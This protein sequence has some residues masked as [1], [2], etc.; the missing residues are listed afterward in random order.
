MADLVPVIYSLRSAVNE[1]KSP[2]EQTEVVVDGLLKLER[3]YAGFDELQVVAAAKQM[4]DEQVVHNGSELSV[5][6]HV[7]EKGF[8]PVKRALAHAHIPETLSPDQLLDFKFKPAATN[9]KQKSGGF[10]YAFDFDSLPMFE[11]LEVHLE[12]LR[13][14]STDRTALTKIMIMDLS[15]LIEHPQWEEA[16][17]LLHKALS[18]PQD[19]DLKLLVLTLFQRFIVGFMGTS[20]GLDTT[21][22]ALRYLLTEWALSGGENGTPL[23]DR[24]VLRAQLALF[25]SAL[26]CS[27]TSLQ[28]PYQREVDRAL[29]LFFVLLSRGQLRPAEGPVSLLS[30]LARADGGEEALIALLRALHPVSAFN[31]AVETGLL[32]TL[33]HPSDASAQALHST[34][35][36]LR[37]VLSLVA[38]FSFGHNPATRFVESCAT[39][40][41]VGS[42]HFDF[43]AHEWR[44][45]LQQL[46]APAVLGRGGAGDYLAPVE[47]TNKRFLHLSRP[48]SVF[49]ALLNPTEGGDARLLSWVVQQLETLLAAVSRTSEVTTDTPDGRERI[50]PLMGDALR[51]CLV[52]CASYLDVGI[53]AANTTTAAFTQ[54]ITQRVLELEAVLAHVRGGE[55]AA[56]DGRRGILR[57][58]LEVADA[59]RQSSILLKQDAPFSWGA[60]LA[61]VNSWNVFASESSAETPVA[62]VQLQDSALTLVAALVDGGAV[63]AGGEVVLL[64]SA[65]QFAVRVVNSGA[66]SPLLPR[67][68]CL[69]H[70][71]LHREGLRRRT[72]E[73][74]AVILALLRALLQP[75]FVDA[76]SE[77]ARRRAVAALTQALFT[78]GKEDL[79]R[80]FGDKEVDAMLT[81]ALRAEMSH[82][83]CFERA[84]CE[85]LP[86]PI[87]GTGDV[88][89]S[90]FQLLLK[91]MRLGYADVVGE[92][93][94]QGWSAAVTEGTG[95]SLSDLPLLHV[96][97]ARGGECAA[98]L[99]TTGIFPYLLRLLV[100]G[101][102]HPGYVE[103]LR[104]RLGTSAVVPA[105]SDDGVDI[106]TVFCLLTSA[107]LAGDTVDPRALL[108]AP[109]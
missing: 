53:S 94:Q 57:G 59:Q 30:A 29:V 8:E 78:A 39:V 40:S 1:S 80:I 79:V 91:L 48:V 33:L 43:S 16:L 28:V 25:V 26:Q 73:E 46:A 108:C 55:T 6:N 51:L 107:A 18:A 89:P 77:D 49:P 86:S 71:A 87:P 11:G 21:I 52:L 45:E 13:A 5:K 17:Q 35:L 65:A 68:I 41:D 101:L 74:D 69:L 50:V 85:E 47:G 67:C 104:S 15:E 106:T 81:G 27:A 12:C 92:V 83:D 3:L 54:T 20:Q 58:L 75:Q 32:G 2:S 10:S 102:S 109:V 38:A 98:Q 24:R 56:L 99:E 63:V 7:H 96:S 88:F 70:S 22:S 66:T 19:P 97:L 60:V 82:P 31:Y 14:N 105:Q 62:V 37:V 103:Q 34:G 9:K 90:A 23:P 64:E 84:Y 4:L 93:V 36:R 61:A 100:A 76:L 72:G 44:D 95:L 42:Q